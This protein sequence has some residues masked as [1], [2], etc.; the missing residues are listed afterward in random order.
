MNDESMS[1]VSVV[2][3]T[4]Q[5]A[6]WL[7]ATVQSI[8]RQTHAPLEILIVDDGSTDETA[9][10][11]RALPDPVRYLRQENAGVSAARNRA[12]A[13][14]RGTWIALADSDDLWAPEKL[15]VQLAALAEA[16][17]A[18]WAASGCRLIGLDDRPVDGRQ[19]FEAV[20][21]VFDAERVDAD[22]WFRRWLTRREVHSAGGVHEVFLGD[23]FGLLFHGNVVLPSSALI[24]REVFEHVGDFDRELRLAEETEFFHRAAAAFPGVM[25]STAL[26][27]YRVAQAGSL[28]NPTNTPVLIR[29]ALASLDAAAQRRAE[30]TP[31]E[32]AAHAAGRARLLRDL[33]YAELS[34]LDGRAARTAQRAAWDAGSSRD[35]RS[36]AVYA[37]GLLPAGVLR[38]IHGVKRRISDRSAA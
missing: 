24:H 15:E 13:E 30:L 35:A 16:P 20:F 11:C 21:G 10:V 17:D 2:L 7:P 22:A 37:A 8:L 29:N 26:V 32:R 36:A 1:M 38:A 23:F 4:Y 18:R 5:R 14:A 25:V 12:I 9:E 34:L 6:T 33:A 3:P 31:A 27:D 28:T 19:G